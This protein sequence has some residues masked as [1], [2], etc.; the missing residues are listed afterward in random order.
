M[1][2][3]G[4]IPMNNLPMKPQQKELHVNLDSRESLTEATG[5][6]DLDHG[7]QLLTQLV[8]TLWM[9]PDLPDAERTS[10]AQA[11]IA[12]LRGIA[13]RDE[14]EGLLATQMLS[15]H[16]AVMECMRRS[17]IPDI[18]PQERDSSLRHAAK[19][20]TIFMKQLETLNRNRGK[21]QPKVTVEHVQVQSGGRAVVGNIENQSPD[22][23]AEHN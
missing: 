10:K 20:F 6:A 12:A 3:I 15:T 8:D 1:E 22:G 9:P 14:L 17:M 7:R 4:V 21:C 13:P 11:A 23:A 5:T 2:T 19:L 18:S 16:A